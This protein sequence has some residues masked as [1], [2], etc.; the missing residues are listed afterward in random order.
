MTLFPKNFN[1]FN[2]WSKDIA[3]EMQSTSKGKLRIG[4]NKLAAIMAATLPGSKQSFNI[5]TLKAS[6]DSPIEEKHIE[7]TEVS[8][9]IELA[10]SDFYPFL[11]THQVEIIKL[12]RNS[13]L[14]IDD[15]LEED[16]SEHFTGFHQ[17]LEADFDIIRKELPLIDKERINQAYTNETQNDPRFLDM[18]FETITWRTIGYAYREYLKDTLYCFLDEI[19]AFYQDREVTLSNDQLQK[20]LLSASKLWKHNDTTDA[21]VETIEV[22]TGPKEY[23]YEV[24]VRA[25][26]S[27]GDSWMQEYELPAFWSGGDYT[28]DEDDNGTLRADC[29]VTVTATSKDDA[30]ATALSDA[31]DL[32]IMFSEANVDLWVD[33]DQDDSVTLIK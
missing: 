9:L 17:P 28:N 15:Q 20:W 12:M 7:K 4:S 6:L 14:S 22:I 16:I 23:E 2:V 32:N 8:S 3:L 31:P 27:G 24:C 25:I 11:I 33:K 19:D 21:F 13:E 1:D 26:I 18:N 10:T 5:N 30:I 29:T